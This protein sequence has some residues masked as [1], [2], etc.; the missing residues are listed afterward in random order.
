[1]EQRDVSARDAGRGQKNAR[2]GGQK[3]GTNI[4]SLRSVV[5]IRVTIKNQGDRYIIADRKTG[6]A[7]QPETTSLE[8]TLSARKAE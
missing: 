7:S 1:M 6:V 2:I 5:A 8:L 4:A 3:G